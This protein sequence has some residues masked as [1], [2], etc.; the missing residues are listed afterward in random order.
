[1]KIEYTRLNTADANFEKEFSKCEKSFFEILSNA[2]QTYY[3]IEY[4]KKR[5]IDG[6]SIIYLAYVDNVLVGV[7]Y[8][9]FNCR[10]GGTAIYPDKY[11]RLG[12]AEN[13]VKLSLT[14]FPK[15]YSILSTNLEHSYKMI[16]L[17]NKL[18]FKRAMTVEEIQKVVG[19]E[20]HL[21]SNFRLD[22]EYMIFDRESERRGGSKRQFLI[23]MHTF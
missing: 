10:R 21:L 19:G 1:M 23:L 15:Q 17:M 16:S 7:S 2:Y 22:N 5:M 8:V 12:L 11:K 4:H 13:L 3:G 14:D 9:K 18:G 6:K 20:F